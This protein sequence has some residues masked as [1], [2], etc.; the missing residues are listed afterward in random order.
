MAGLPTWTCLAHMGRMV[1]GGL[2]CLQAVLCF[3]E[4]L[5]GMSRGLSGGSGGSWGGPGTVPAI[6]TAPGEEAALLWEVLGAGFVEPSTVALCLRD[7]E[8]WGCPQPEVT[9]GLG[10]AGPLLLGRPSRMFICGDGGASVPAPQGSVQKKPAAP[11]AFPR[12]TA[13]T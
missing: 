10:P 12:S 3:L 9:W 6:V 1:L 5:F 4:W 7:P 13:A 11:V 2:G 8:Q